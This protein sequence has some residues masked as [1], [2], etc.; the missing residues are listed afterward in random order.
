M[1]SRTIITK[2]QSTIPP[3]FG[4]TL[5][6]CPEQPIHKAFLK[7]TLPGLGTYFRWIQYIGEA[8][9]KQVIIKSSNSKNTLKYGGLFLHIF[10]QLTSSHIE[11]YNRMIGQIIQEISNVHFWLIANIH[12]NV[13]NHPFGVHTNNS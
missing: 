11:S 8:I 4:D 2:N 13:K 1:T 12:N 6:F 7:L 5:T 9:L 3:R 10:T